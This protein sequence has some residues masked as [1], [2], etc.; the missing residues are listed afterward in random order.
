MQQPRYNLHFAG[1]LCAV[2]MWIFATLP[3]QYNSSKYSSFS[4]RHAQ[5]H[6]KELLVFPVRDPDEDPENDP[7]EDSNDAPFDV[8]INI[9]KDGV[10]LSCAAGLQFLSPLATQP[11]R[12]PTFSPS[13]TAPITLLPPKIYPLTSPSTFL[14]MVPISN[15]AAG[16]R[17]SSPPVTHLIRVPT[18]S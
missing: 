16:L 11:T 2:P 9:L 8:P 1:T 5:N 12:V 6:G 3:L 7:K 13:T 15:C 18:S 4:G 14:V 17:S 10:H